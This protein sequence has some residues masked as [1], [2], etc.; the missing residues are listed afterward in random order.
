MFASQP[1]VNC[2]VLH[3]RSQKS[4][5]N[6]SQRGQPIINQQLIRNLFSEQFAIPKPRNHNKYN[7]REEE[8]KEEMGN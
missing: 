6:M 5:A 8:T 4:D 7:G 1:K 2:E 3:H